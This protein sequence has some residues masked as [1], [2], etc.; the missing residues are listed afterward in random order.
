MPSVCFQIKC[1]L[2]AKVNKLDGK[3]RNYLK[4][5]IGGKNT[6]NGGKNTFN[7]SQVRKEFKSLKKLALATYH[8]S[9]HR[10]ICYC[11]KK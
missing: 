6:F 3:F 11:F 5:T 9:F 7:V 4:W 2:T 10:F 8:A 1:K